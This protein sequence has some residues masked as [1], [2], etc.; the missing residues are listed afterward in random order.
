MDDPTAQLQEARRSQ[1][2]AEARNLSRRYVLLSASVS[3]LPL[4]LLDITAVLG[5]QL[6]LVYDLAKLYEM[7]FESRLVKPLL[8]SLLSCG[9]VSGGSV[10][11]IALGMA[12]P[13]LRTL[14]GGGFSGGLAG[15]TLA[16]SEIFIRHFESGGTLQD[17]AQKNPLTAA[18]STGASSSTS[19]LTEDPPKSPPVP[20]QSV[21]ER[22][23]AEHAPETP[24]SQKSEPQKLLFDEIYGIGT[25]YRGRL[26]SHGIHNLHALAALD[27][28]ELKVILGPRVSLTTARDFISQAKTFLNINSS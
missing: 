24:D 19:S 27:P 28:E 13:P 11:L 7:P 23:L 6:K 9:A 16:T 17:F 2:L 1:R 21:E 4:P 8:K 25:V 3:L 22:E 5:I 10:A 14:V 12:S 26:V 20:D 18:T 15:S